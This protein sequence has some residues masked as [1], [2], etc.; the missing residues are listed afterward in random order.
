MSITDGGNCELVSVSVD[1]S[2]EDQGQHKEVRS[3]L[4]QNNL[5]VDLTATSNSDHYSVDKDDDEEDDFPTWNLS[6]IE[7]EEDD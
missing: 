4:P 5:I 3:L 2:H 6:N 1:G 7:D